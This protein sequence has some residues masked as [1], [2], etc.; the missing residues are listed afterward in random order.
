MTG[1]EYSINEVKRLAEMH[2]ISSRTKTL[3]QQNMRS[4]KVCNNAIDMRFLPAQN[5]QKTVVC[6]RD[7]GQKGR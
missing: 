5:L 4:Y 3:C 7:H 1:Y 6:S 2:H